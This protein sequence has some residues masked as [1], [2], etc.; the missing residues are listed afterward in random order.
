[1]PSVPCIPNPRFYTF[2]KYLRNAFE[3]DAALH[4]DHFLLSPSLVESL[5]GANSM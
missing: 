5:T 4:I 1:M 3:R 2:R